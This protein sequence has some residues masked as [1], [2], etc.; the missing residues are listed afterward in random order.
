MIARGYAETEPAAPR[1]GQ[2]SLRV[3][4]TEEA[5]Q[6]IDAHFDA[7]ARYWR[8]VYRLPDVQGTIYRQRQALALALA[9]ELGLS[10]GA[11]ILEVGCGAGSAAVALAQRGHTVEAVDSVPAMIHLTRRL[12]AEAGVAARVRT[13]V[14]D[15][16]D[17]AFG[18]GTFTLVL[19]LGVVPW[20]RRL[21]AVLEELHAVL[22]PGGHLIV[23]ADNLWRLSHLLDP[24]WFPPLL[25]IRA[26]G[27]RILNRTG[28]IAAPPRPRHHLHSIRQLDRALARHGFEKV[29]GVTLGFGPFSFFNRRL[30]TEPAGVRLHRL[31]QGLADRGLPGIRALGSQY[32]VLARKPP[33]TA[34][35]RGSRLEA[36]P[37]R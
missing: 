24:W 11:G 31:L 27:R 26:R 36:P 20:V 2:G 34:R 32:V 16:H 13:I 19:A 15:V 22:E 18:D 10:S 12:A 33:G 14:G 37:W 30:L 6:R 25:P 23:S 1:A 5:Q 8:D 35:R 17:L 29:R 3:V 4:G 7:T 21:A 28:A 9:T